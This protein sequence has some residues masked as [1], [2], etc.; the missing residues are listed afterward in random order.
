MTEKNERDV[1]RGRLGPLHERQQ[2]VFDTGKAAISVIA[3]AI[4][5]ERVVAMAAMVDRCDIDAAA[6]NRF[7]RRQIA[8]R[9]LAHS[10]GDQHHRA[11]RLARRPAAHA[12]RDPVALAKPKDG[13]CNRRVGH[14]KRAVSSTPKRRG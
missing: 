10:V 4:R 14:R 7:E 6:N 13:L 8:S 5:R 2:V 1:R 9:M 12:R 11:R 3:K